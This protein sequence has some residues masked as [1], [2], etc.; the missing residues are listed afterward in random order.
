M[1]YLSRFFPKVFESSWLS[2]SNIERRM[3]IFKIIKHLLSKTG[4]K[5]GGWEMTSAQ[6]NA[7]MFIF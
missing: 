3:E 1:L 7:D 5:L 4:R 6:P 2:Q